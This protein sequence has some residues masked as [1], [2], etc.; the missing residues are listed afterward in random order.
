MLRA[1]MATHQTGDSPIINDVVDVLDRALR[2][3]ISAVI[4][5]PKI[6]AERHIVNGIHESAESLRIYRFANNAVLDCD[7]VA[8]L[9][10]AETIPTSPLDR[11]VIDRK[12]TRLNSSH[13]SES[14]M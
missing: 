14:R 1:R 7:V 11:D 6:V 2:F 3:R 9:S 8:A 5:N 13:V 4:V 12:S 10:E